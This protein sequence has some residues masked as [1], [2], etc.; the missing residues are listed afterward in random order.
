MKRNQLFCLSLFLNGLLILAVACNSGRSGNSGS[1]T[2][3]P[4][5][6]AH[7]AFIG[8][9]PG[10]HGLSAKQT[11]SFD[12]SLVPELHAQSQTTVSF[13]GSYSGYCSQ[14][15]PPSDGNVSAFVLYG[16]GS[17]DPSTSCSTW[18]ENTDAGLSAAQNANGGQLVI[19]D[20]TLGPLVA[21]A[22]SSSSTV[23]AFVNR[24]GT[25]MDTGIS[26]TLNGSVPVTSTTTFSVLNGDLVIVTA[27]S[28][29]TPSTNLQFVLAKE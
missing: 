5:S 6:P 25:V 19:G 29:G 20:G 14:L 10:F 12:F 24:A 16:A 8:A 7:H 23:R 9:V 22:G 18:Y 2:T 3:T 4:P 26:A 17:L 11:T 21:W 13:T 1:S 28:D 15:T 27:Q